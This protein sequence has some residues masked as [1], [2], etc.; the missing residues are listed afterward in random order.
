M[1][2]VD[3][4]KVIEPLGNSDHNTV[5]F[6]MNINADRRFTFQ[7]YLS[8]ELIQIDWYTVMQNK[9]VKQ[10]WDIFKSKLNSMINKYIPVEN[11]FQE[12]RI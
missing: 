4:V 6:E 2:L 3:N 7:I 12:E 9:N 11:G 8:E 1:E 5:M 10:S